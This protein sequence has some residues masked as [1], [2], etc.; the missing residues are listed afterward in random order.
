M[1]KDTP[2]QKELHRIFRGQ[3]VVQLWVFREAKK[4]PHGQKSKGAA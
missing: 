2:T 3:K 4:E 1:S